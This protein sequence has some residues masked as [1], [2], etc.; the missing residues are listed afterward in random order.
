MGG[1]AGLKQLGPRFA[2]KGTFP[3]LT[4]LGLRGCTAL[5]EFPSV[6][7]GAFPKL[8][9]L[10]MGYCAGVKQLGARFASKG[11]FLALTLLELR[12]CTALE[13]FPSVEEGAFPK[14]ENLYMGG[15][16]GVKQL[17]AQFASKGTF[18]A[19]TIWIMVQHRES[20]DLYKKQG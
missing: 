5:E 3:A 6:E 10:Y 9:N 11:T 2:S 18:P 12:G 4:L 7:E 8:E 20:V 1:C 14:L 15:C 16:G 13:E 19:L 17:G